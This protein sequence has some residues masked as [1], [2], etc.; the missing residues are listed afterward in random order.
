MYNVR[1]PPPREKERTDKT[2]E[3]QRGQGGLP[4]IPQLVNVTGGAVPCVF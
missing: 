1:I 2:A 3:V 4:A